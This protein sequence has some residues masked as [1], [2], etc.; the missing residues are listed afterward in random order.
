MRAAPD[1]RRP[2][3]LYS[4]AAQTALVTLLV[5]AL[6]LVVPAVGP[7]RG[8]AHDFIS[9]HL[10]F[11]HHHAEHAVHD[12]AAASD[13]DAD[14]AD[15]AYQQ[16]ALSSAGPIA[17]AASLASKGLLSSTLMLALAGLALSIGRLHG[18]RRPAPR[19]DTVPTGPPR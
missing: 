17:E 5:V 6:A 14:L 18:Q 8:G 1:T 10:I 19:W 3:L 15:L 11:P 12:E 4:E 9:V 2:N 7:A 16:P 13:W